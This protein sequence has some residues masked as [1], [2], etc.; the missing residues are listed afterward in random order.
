MFSLIVSNGGAL[1]FILYAILDIYIQY[2]IIYEKYSILNEILH[3]KLNILNLII[4]L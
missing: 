4:F 3:L 1:G 2:I